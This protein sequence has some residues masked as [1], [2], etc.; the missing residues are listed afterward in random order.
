MEE[1]R[2]CDKN[3]NKNK[4]FLFLFY[5]HLLLITILVIFLT[6]KGFL[7]SSSTTVCACHRFHPRHW[8]PPLL[9]SSSFAALLAFLFLVAATHK[10]RVTFWV[11]PLLTCGSGFLFLYIGT[12]GSFVV[13]V[14]TL[15][16][17]LIQS[18]YTCWVVPRMDYATRLLSVSLPSGS[19]LVTNMCSVAGAIVIGTVFSCFLVLGMGGARAIF[20]IQRWFYFLYMFLIILSLAWGM[21]VIRSVLHIAI[22]R[23][24]YMYFTQ[25]R[26]ELDLRQ[27]L[28]DAMKYSLGSACLGSALVLLLGI[29]QGS[30]RAM[31]SVA[32]D[33][34][35]FMFSCA[36]CYSGIARKVVAYGNRWGFV[37]VGV[38]GKG[39]V[40]ASRDVWETFR[41]VG[42]ESVIDSDLTSSFCFLCGVA[43]GSACSLVGGSWAVVVEK[44]YATEVSIYGFLI[45]YFIVRIAMSL[46]E[47]W[48]SAY[49]VAYADNPQ[50]LDF[51]STIR[52]RIKKLQQAS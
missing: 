22:S 3:K 21:H 30:A 36:S 49:Y 12:S 48:V 8:Y 10:L 15:V 14:F 51:D 18:V 17:A 39:I 26:V 35:E 25:Q 16:F 11:S 47:A 40:K 45:G 32:G 4:V 43:G 13:A 46:T 23:V 34:D 33:T 42:M 9:I 2:H 41:K 19:V 28:N 29:V 37:H 38:Y 50:S 31:V 52:D 44:S 6:I 20:T 5:V 7:L 27:A 24:G 1:E